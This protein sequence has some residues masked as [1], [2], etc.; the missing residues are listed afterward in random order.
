LSQVQ[1]RWLVSSAQANPCRAYE[2]WLM[3]TLDALTKEYGYDSDLKKLAQQFEAAQCYEPSLRRL[4]QLHVAPY[5]ALFLRVGERWAVAPA[6]AAEAEGIKRLLSLQLMKLAPKESF[7]CQQPLRDWNPQ[8]LAEAA[9]L[10]REYQA[11]AHSIAP[12]E[13]SLTT[14]L[15]RKQLHAVL[16]E[17]MNHAQRRL[18]AADGSTGA[19]VSDLSTSERLLDEQASNLARV[20]APLLETLRMYQQLGFVASHA[21]I[22]QCV[23]EYAVQVLQKTQALADASQLYAPKVEASSGLPRQIYA[24]G[25]TPVTMDY[26]SRQLQ[27]SQVLASRAEPFVALLKNTDG[28]YSATG[29]GVDWEATLQELNRYVNFKGS[30]GQVEQLHALFLKQLSVLATD[31]CDKTLDAYVPGHYGKDLFSHRRVRLV[32]QSQ[33]YCAKLGG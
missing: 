27:R 32:Q 5:G 18:V 17:T 3:Q 4:A 11:F 16:D 6:V 13:Q 33:L 30:S 7:V 10:M 12:G 20:S 2:S 14:R 1:T 31:N 8:A 26:L 29:G 23:R 21:A 22:N 24:L 28:G 25:S 19:S 15:A 9:A